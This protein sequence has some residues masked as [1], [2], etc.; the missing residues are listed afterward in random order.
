MGSVTSPIAVL[1]LSEVASSSSC[2]EM[3]RAERKNAIEMRHWMEL[4]LIMVT[5]LGKAFR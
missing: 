3:G 2:Q 5:L 4:I 1:S